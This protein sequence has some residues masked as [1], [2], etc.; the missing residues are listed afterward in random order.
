MTASTGSRAR[1]RLSSGSPR[2]VSST[3]PKRSR[4][5]PGEADSISP[6]VKRPGSQDHSAHVECGERHSLPQ[7]AFYAALRDIAHELGLGYVARSTLAFADFSD[8]ADLGR[9]GILRDHR[10]DHAIA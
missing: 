2:K 3:F 7:R 10:S 5:W 4:A 6:A 9:G 1:P 8:V